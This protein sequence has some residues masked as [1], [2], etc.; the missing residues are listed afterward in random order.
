MRLVLP[1]TALLLSAIFMSGCCC[2]PAKTVLYPV[3]YK[4]KEYKIS[5]GD[6]YT[7]SDRIVNW[8]WAA[9]DDPDGVPNPAGSDSYI[10]LGEPLIKY[11][12]GQWLP[13]LFIR[14]DNGIITSFTCSV[15][16]R[17]K[18]EPSGID[19]FFDIL[20]ESISRLTDTEVREVL[21]ESG[22]YEMTVTGFMETFILT[23]SEGEAYD[24][25]EYTVQAVQIQK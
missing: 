24:R 2:G 4:S 16:F 21:K 5:L 13:S 17:M 15:L 7:A 12:C 3:D 8:S 10:S 9:L 18:E 25:F 1:L 6:S 23:P 20:G 11:N 19:D 22:Y 14:T